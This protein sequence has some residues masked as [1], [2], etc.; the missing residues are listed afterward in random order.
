MVKVLLIGAVLATASLAGC[1]G[2]SADVHTAARANAAPA[3]PGESTYTITRIASQEAS[4]DHQ[5]FE[6][7]V[8]D[9]LARHGFADA[10]DKAAHYLLS[11]AYATRPVTVS[12][13]TPDCAPGDCAHQAETPFSLFGARVYQHSLTLRFFDHA[14][15]EERYKVSA[16]TNDRDADPL[17]AMPTLVKSALAKLPFDASSDWRVTLRTDKTGSVPEVVSVKPLQP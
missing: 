11:I 13:S 15:G 8:R 17:H 5:R 1:A 7:L 16:I 10:P 9:E 14:S 2:L 12:V 3:L 6:A 4:A